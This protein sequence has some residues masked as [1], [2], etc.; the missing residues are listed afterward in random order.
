MKNQI[1]TKQPI[2]QKK[3]KLRAIIKSKTQN[4]LTQIQMEKLLKHLPYGRQY[5]I[6]VLYGGD[7]VFP[8]LESLV[9]GG[10]LN[11]QQFPLGYTDRYPIALKAEL[12][13][14]NSL[15]VLVFDKESEGSTK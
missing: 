6:L 4:R 5:R 13:S 10:Y 12:D 1:F 7:A 3:E 11:L 8:V 9:I 14:S 15:L 2:L